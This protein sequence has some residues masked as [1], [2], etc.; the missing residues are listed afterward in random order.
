VSGS[1]PP[2]TEVTGRYVKTDDPG[3]STGVYRV[4]CREHG[5]VTHEES[6]F[7]VKE[8][9]LAQAALYRQRHLAKH[10]AALSSEMTEAAR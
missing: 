10:L 5:D 9:P 4:I 6:G 1:I 2:L 8:A 7:S 3:H